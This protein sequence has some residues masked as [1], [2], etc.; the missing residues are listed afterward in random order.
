MN[1]LFREE[2]YHEIGRNLA[3]SFWDYYK[4]MGVIPLDPSE[5]AED[6][7]KVAAGNAFNMNRLQEI[8]EQRNTTKKIMDKEDSDDEDGGG[9]GKVH[10]RCDSDS[11]CITDLGASIIDD[12]RKAF[13][14]FAHLPL[15]LIWN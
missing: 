9:N 6:A 11:P 1:T 3:R 8:A 5:L 7:D 2:S 4:I 14:F 13:G 10:L 15:V 12:A